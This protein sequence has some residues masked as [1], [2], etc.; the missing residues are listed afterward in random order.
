MRKFITLVENGKVSENMIDVTDADMRELIRAAYDQS[1]PQGLGHLHFTPGP[2]DEEALEAIHGGLSH[3]GM[4]PIEMDYV[5]GRSI[6]LAVFRGEFLRNDYGAED[7]RL[8]VAARW[9]DHTDEQMQALLDR[10]GVEVVLADLPK[11]GEAP[12]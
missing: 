9:Y 3:P 4:T 8:Y 2:L 12:Q 5:R 6:K 11:R 1:S 10:I 7:G